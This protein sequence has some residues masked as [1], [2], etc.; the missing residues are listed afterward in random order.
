M[1]YGAITSTDAGVLEKVLLEFKPAGRV[2]F[3]EIGVWNGETS[4][5]VANFCRENGIKLDYWGIDPNP[6]PGFQG[7]L[8]VGKSEDVFLAIP[9]DF[10]V[11]FTDGCHCLTHA[12]IDAAIYRL[13]VVPG[14]FML[15][16]DTSPRVQHTQR[17]RWVHGDE[18]KPIYRTAVLDALEFM[19]WPN[20]NWRLFADDFDPN[21]DIGGMKS[22]R[23]EH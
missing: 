8:I 21:S 10:N 6:S 3:L 16:H 20:D 5:G 9:D 1:K 14:G 2:K 22:F 7:T 18:D 19:G 15:F 17:N 23:R 11:I 12:V 4:Q 13:K